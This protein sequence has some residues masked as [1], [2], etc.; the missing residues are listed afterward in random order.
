MNDLL[1]SVFRTI[2]VIPIFTMPWYQ[3]SEGIS[4]IL[5][6]Q[7]KTFLQVLFSALYGSLSVFSVSLAEYFSFKEVVSPVLGS[8]LR[9]IGSHLVSGLGLYFSPMPQFL[10]KS[11]PFTCI[12]DYL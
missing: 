3:D 8:F 11:V 9:D 10:V 1:S 2:I 5:H 6:L 12:L 7:A 4:N